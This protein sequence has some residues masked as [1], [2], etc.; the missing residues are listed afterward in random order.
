M[1]LELTDAGFDASVLSEFRTRLVTGGAEQ[2]LLATLLDRF[3]ERQWL[4]AR[5]RQRTDST[6]VLAA[7]RTRNRLP[8]RRG[9]AAAGPQCA[10]GGRARLG[11]GRSS[12]GRGRPLGSAL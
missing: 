1:G 8:Q 6:P 7:I 10:G 5:G 4:K 3:R 2:P 11:T 12:A 9:D